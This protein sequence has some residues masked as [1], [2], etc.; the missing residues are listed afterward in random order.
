MERLQINPKTE[1][2]YEYKQ[3]NNV[4]TDIARNVEETSRFGA[5]SGKAFRNLSKEVLRRGHLMKNKANV[6][7]TEEKL[8]FKVEIKCSKPTNH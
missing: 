8:T 3:R 4:S 6:N 7:S 5:R 1:P 2:D